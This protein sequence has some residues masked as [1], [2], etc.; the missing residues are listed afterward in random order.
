MF[1]YSTTTLLRDELPSGVSLTYAP[2]PSTP[3]A[4][5]DIQESFAA[6]LS[7]NANNGMFAYTAPLEHMM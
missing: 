7:E 4:A 1:G 5:I 3:G 2:Y 6:M